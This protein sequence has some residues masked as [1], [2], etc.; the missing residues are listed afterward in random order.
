MKKFLNKAILELDV[1]YDKIQDVI[2]LKRYEKIKT[3]PNVNHKV[4]IG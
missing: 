3:P 4:T 1:R 2:A